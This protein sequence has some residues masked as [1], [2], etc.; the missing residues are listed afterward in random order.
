MNESIE[1]S[2]LH[3]CGRC[4]WMNENGIMYLTVSLCVICI[5]DFMWCMY[6]CTTWAWVKIDE[7]RTVKI[8]S[9]E[10]VCSQTFISFIY[11]SF[12]LFIRLPVCPF[13][14][15]HKHL[16]MLS[17]WIKWNRFHFLNTQTKLNSTP[18]SSW[19]RWIYSLFYL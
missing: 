14:Y 17:V 16:H 8:G 7:Q 10:T 6:V 1:L 4:E 12:I 19:D 13:V 11:R 18:K 3:T 2:R 15:T 5:D 9:H